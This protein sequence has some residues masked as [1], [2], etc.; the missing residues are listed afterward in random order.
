MW[1]IAGTR[2][3]LLFLLWP[4]K[5]FYTCTCEWSVIKF[6]FKRTILKIPMTVKSAEIHFRKMFF[7]SCFLYCQ[8]RFRSAFLC[9]PTLRCFG[10]APRMLNA[11]I[12]ESVKLFILL[13]SQLV[14]YAHWGIFSIPWESIAVTNVERLLSLPPESNECWRYYITLAFMNKS[15]Y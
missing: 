6:S 11:L 1:V 9:S 14:R 13:R 12:L 8:I 7:M 3:Q 5:K 15:N 10:I 4:P 2:L